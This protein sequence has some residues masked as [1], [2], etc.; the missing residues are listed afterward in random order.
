MNT[1]TTIIGIIA[2]VVVLFA[3]IHYLMPGTETLRP[4]KRKKTTVSDSTTAP[5]LGS[6]TTLPAVSD[7]STRN[8]SLGILTTAKNGATDETP[9]E[10]K[11]SSQDTIKDVSNQAAGGYKAIGDRD[12][13]CLLIAPPPP[14]PPPRETIERLTLNWILWEI[15]S[16]QECVLQDTRTQSHNLQV[17]EVLDKVKVNTIDA[18]QNRVE[19]VVAANPKDSRWVQ[20]QPLS[21][22][23]AGW[24]LTGSVPG[25]KMA[26]VVTGDRKVNK[27]KEGEILQHVKIKQVLQNKVIFEYGTMTQELTP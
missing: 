20:L 2:I 12:L 22:V 10:F 9:Y 21:T 6:A 1:R 26:Y 8:F 27:V 18:S 15:P 24:K 5:V 11:E 16:D 3:G 7:K 14:P 13:F 17:G 25:L 19:L 23:V 4:T